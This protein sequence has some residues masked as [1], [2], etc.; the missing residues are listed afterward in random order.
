[1]AADNAT[2]ALELLVSLP[3]DK[4]AKAVLQTTARQLCWRRPKTE[5]LMRVVPTQN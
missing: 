5:P 1:M 3:E 2:Y 4:L